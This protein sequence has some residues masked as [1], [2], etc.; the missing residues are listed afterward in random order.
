M[1]CFINFP[2]VLPP[3]PPDIATIEACEEGCEVGIDDAE[4][5]AWDKCVHLHDLRWGVD[6]TCG[7]NGR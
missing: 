7:Y 3:D 4:I 1:F 2:I 5:A 6:N